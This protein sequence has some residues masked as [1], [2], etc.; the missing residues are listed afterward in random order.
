VNDREE[1]QWETTPSSVLGDFPM[2]VLKVWV[3]CISGDRKMCEYR[4]Y[5]YR[6][7]HHLDTA[8]DNHMS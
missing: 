6:T 4:R 1:D 3:F 5:I 8:N 7:L 2:D